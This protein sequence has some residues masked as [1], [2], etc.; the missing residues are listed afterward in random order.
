VLILLGSQQVCRSSRMHCRA[1]AAA[2]SKTLRQPQEPAPA[3]CLRAAPAQA[4]HG[5][6]ML[7]LAPKRN[8]KM[9][10]DSQQE[11]L[12]TGKMNA[13]LWKSWISQSWF[14]QIDASESIVEAFEKVT[15]FYKEWLNQAVFREQGTTILGGGQLVP[16]QAGEKSRVRAAFPV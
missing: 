11:P 14:G 6:A 8:R 12:H 15:T 2:G 7:H 1:A 16:M 10:H 3:P 4:E 13:F 5:W 9:G